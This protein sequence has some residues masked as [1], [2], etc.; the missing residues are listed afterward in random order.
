MKIQRKTLYLWALDYFYI[1][2]V[3]LSILVSPFL[4]FHLYKRINKSKLLILLFT[5]LL[6]SLSI[7]FFF[8]IK[9]LHLDMVVNICFEYP[10]MI[11]KDSNIPKECYK[12]E[13][14]K[15]TGVGWTLSAILWMI[16]GFI[17][18]CFTNISAQVY[19]RYRKI[20]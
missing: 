5:F 15:Y 3:V 14:N 7:V 8:W 19:N 17:Y 13:Y 9:S 2:C 18:L 4:C 16:L 12:F 10:S 1:S 6:L 20:K 11:Y